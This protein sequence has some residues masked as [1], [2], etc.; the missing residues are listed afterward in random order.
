[1]I[2]HTYSGR[3]RKP[4]A[5]FTLCLIW[6]MLLQGQ[7][8]LAGAYVD[9]I[10]PLNPGRTTP[11]ATLYGPSYNNAVFND[12]TVVGIVNNDP[13]RTPSTAD[14]VS[15]VT[16]NNYHDETDVAIRGRNGL[17]YVFTRTYNSV[18]SV[19]PAG[20]PLAGQARDQGLGAGW[21]HSYMMRL[22]TNDF[23]SCPSCTAS[24]RPENGDGLTSSIT[25]TDE[26]GA[27]H[28]FLV[29]GNWQITPPQGSFDQLVVQGN[30]LIILQ[31][32]NG[33]QYHFRH[34]PESQFISIGGTIARLVAIVKEPGGQRLDMQYDEVG[35]L[36]RV[37][38]NLNIAGRTGLT[39]SYHPDQVHLREVADWTGRRWT[40]G[41]QGNRLVSRTDPLQQTTSY[42]Y[43]N[44]H[45][46]TRVTKPLARNGQAVETRFKYYDNRRTFKQTN[47]YDQGDTLDYD[48]YRRSTRVTDARGFTREYHYDENGRMTKLV[49]PDG[50]VLQ[51]ENQAD[52]MRF[53]KYDAL[54]Y[55]TTY[56]YRSDRAF[57][58]LADQEN[59]TR[60]QDALGRNVDMNYNAR[61]ELT[62][63]TNRRGVTT[64]TAFGASTSGCDNVARPKDVRVAG[65]GLMREYCWN[66]DATPSWQRDYMTDTR[67]R[68]TRLT[69]QP[70]TNGLNVQQEQLVGMPSGIAITKTYTYDALGRKRTE[71]LMRRRSA[72]DAT[73]VALT[74]NIVYDDLDRVTQVTDPLGNEIHNRFDANGQLWQ[75]TH[76]YR[77]SDGSYDVRNVVTRTFDAADRVKTEIDAEGNETAYTYDG[78]GNVI[79][80]LDAEGHTARYEYDAMNRRSAVVSATGARTVTAYNLRGQAISVT[81]PM[82]QKASF[83]FNAL[84]Q[85]TAVVDARGFRSEFTYDA[86]GNL[87]CTLDANAQA[88]L[89]S[90][91][92]DGCTE[93]RI[94]DALDRIERIRDAANGTTVMTYD[95]LGNRTSITDAE[96][97]IWSFGYDDLGRLSSETDHSSRSI[98]YVVDEAGNVVQKTN[99]LAQVTRYTFDNGNRLTRADYLADGSAETFGYDAA[100]N[101]NAA[102]N[103]AVG[104]TFQY[105]RLNR[106]QNKI[107]SRGRSLGFTYDKVGN[108]LTK[109][110]Y[111]G[112]TTSYVYDAGN[113]LVALRNPDYTQVEYQHDPAGRVLSRVTS[114]GARTLYDYDANGWMNRMRHFD[115]ANTAVADTS[116]G[117]DRLGF[118]TSQSDA[119]GTSSYTLD[120]LNR[121]T[122]A[123]RPGT[124]DDEGFTYDKV[125]NRN[126]Y[127]FRGISRH[128]IYQA[129]TNRLAEVRIG[130]PTG[131]LESSFG[132]DNEGRLTSQ[133]GV[134]AK[135]LLWDAKGRVRS[136][137]GESYRYDPMNYRIG[138]SGSGLGSLDYFLEGEHLESVYSGTGQLKEKYFRG[139]GTDE[140]VA[141]FQD[142]GGVLKPF[143]FHQDALTSTIQLTSHNGGTAQGLSY[144]SFGAV[145]ASTGSSPNRLK[146]TGREDDGTGLY[147]YRARYYDPAIGRFVCEDS[148]GFAAGINFYVYAG[149][150]PISANDPLG[151]EPYVAYPTR[152]EAHAAAG[153]WNAA[154]T[155]GMSSAAGL[156]LEFGA[157]IYQNGGSYY[158]TPSVT[159]FFRASDGSATVSES[160]WRSLQSLIPSGSTGVTRDHSHPSGFQQVP[161][162]ADWVGTQSLRGADLYESISLPDGSVWAYRQTRG[163]VS[164]GAGGLSI[165]WTNPAPSAIAPA[166][167]LAPYSFLDR[168]EYPDAFQPQSF[169]D[170]GAAGGYLIYPSRPNNNSTVVV[171]RK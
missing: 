94:Y 35:R 70:G 145:L 165:G 44:R 11:G 136:V 122:G 142:G 71:T 58:G 42:G 50:G 9:G 119:S 102:A 85:R 40:F 150:N 113:R 154:Q 64:T 127:T 29:S 160:A 139:R 81:N 109:T 135:T 129:G 171:Y 95:R 132:Y 101:R 67:Y 43:D 86:N 99:R 104:Y 45:L 120:P 10:S 146:Y 90:R 114:N 55:A 6:S 83:E 115:A 78:A 62:S 125:G 28:L 33:T 147:Y 59:V 52:F 65:I 79:A 25:Y 108:V 60:E 37:V 13:V 158:H 106:L 4:A 164:N 17:D 138:R 92:Q 88:G 22:T 16:G 110:T 27:E 53:R 3:A 151:L 56:S 1:M 97:K 14:P 87:D 143:L 103:A 21:T 167:P 77:R 149:N 48:L 47:S 144:A 30:G 163:A 137:G 72:T 107:D 18:A 148:K 156:S 2:F 46:L 141:A 140:L 118:V 54:G 159:S 152:D 112:S 98:A 117:R 26:R 126:T 23:G 166:S 61:G 128:Y 93:K 49:E 32:R 57:T 100:G 73:L 20:T 89:Q 133:A 24:Q 51:F 91:N 75:V 111:Q 168:V 162:T 121:L 34:D 155:S 74:T 80:V 68:E 169:S 170:S 124:A 105:D 157:Y 36:S 41:Y 66:A 131:T 82:G 76:R 8:V 153:R 31:F 7:Q 19:Q 134:G 69:Y 123:D 12:Q 130:A 63:V 116:Y 38:D 96:N 161:S 5:W 15:T 39:F 84:G